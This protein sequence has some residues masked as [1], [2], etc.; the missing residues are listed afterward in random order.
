MV[1]DPRRPRTPRDAAFRAYLREVRATLRSD[2]VPFTVASRRPLLTGAASS[3]VEVQLTGGARVEPGDMLL[4]W[5]R[6]LPASVDGVGSERVDPTCRGSTVPRRAR[7]TEERFVR[8]VADLSAPG[9]DAVAAPRITPRFY[10]VAGAVAG[11]V[12]LHVTAAHAWPARAADFLHRVG[13]R[14]TVYAWVLRHPHRVDR[15]RGGLAV[16]TGSGAAGVFAALRHGARDVRL[17]W[18][19][20]G[21]DP[22]PWVREELD[23]HVVSGALAEL[24]LARS[25]QRVTDFLARDAVAVRELVADGGWL[26]VSGNER[27]GEAVD[28]L[29]TGIVGAPAIARAR[30]DL[31]YIVST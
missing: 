11:Q 8:A 13:E 27:M 17:V 23:R 18:G 1:N 28:G 5:W 22:E 7:T 3:V 31:R 24:R 19:L 25:P 20:G 10:T 16:A 30:D 6:N 15:T 12:S 29:L 14:E 26:Y 21:K 4:L 9:T 2:P